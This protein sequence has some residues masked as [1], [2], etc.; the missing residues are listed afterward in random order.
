[1]KVFPI[2]GSG[3]ELP[4]EYKVALYAQLFRR[5]SKDMD[6]DGIYRDGDTSNAA[7]CPEYNLR[8]TVDTFRKGNAVLRASAG[9]VGN[10]LGATKLRFRVVL[11]DYERK[12]LL[13]EN[14][15]AKAKGDRESLDVAVKMAKNV[16]KKLKAGLPETVPSN[17]LGR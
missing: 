10:V 2:A 11:T 16:T 1:M 8:L 12:S 15:K 9:P 17:H 13:D 14:F 6:F 3:V 7:S 5:L 4:T